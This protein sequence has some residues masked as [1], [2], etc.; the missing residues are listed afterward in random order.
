M[1]LVRAAQTLVLSLIVIAMGGCMTPPTMAVEHDLVPVPPPPLPP[2]ATGGAIYQVGYDLRLF[3]DPKARRVGDILTIR[4]IERTAATKS[5]QTDTSKDSSLDTGMPII[6]GDDV[7]LNG[8]E[9]LENQWDT[10]QSFKGGG[11]SSQSNKLDGRVTVTVAQVYPNGNLLV[12]GEKQI[13]LN[14]GREYIR[15]TGV[16]RPIDILPDNTIESSRVADAK[17]TY[18]G[19]GAVADAN[20]A[21]WASRFFMSP[22][23]PL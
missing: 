3:D 5:A 13:T 1:K 23:W 19:R 4:L 10:E 2:E 21:G 7:T 16:I 15:I 9:I 8:N 18:S 11:S 22:W 14:Q 12:T 17:I 6:L 20:R